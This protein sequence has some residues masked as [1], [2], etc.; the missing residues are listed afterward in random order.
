M[1]QPAPPA[2]PANKPAAPQAKGAAPPAKNVAPPAKPTPP[3]K[4][5]APPAKNVAPPAKATPPAKSAAPPAEKTAA[6]P[7]DKPAPP[8]KSAAP[9]AESVAPPAEKTAAPPA[10]K[11]AARPAGEIVT[12]LLPPL[13]LLPDEDPEQYALLREAVVSELSPSTPY[14]RIYA[15]QL[16][17]L[18][19][20]LWRYRRFRDGF[21][22]E[23]FRQ[24]CLDNMR[25]GIPDGEPRFSANQDDRQFARDCVSADTKLR[26]MALAALER[27]GY[28][29]SQ[30]VNEIYSLHGGRLERCDALIAEIENR[31]RRLREDF[32]RL[33]S[34]KARQ[35]EDAEVLEVR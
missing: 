4:G 2:P 23:K 32:D 6:P 33:K 34:A 24:W 29:P 18:E 11:P 27:A 13:D 9:P 17:M 15:D 10:D 21:I 14:Q 1:A 20:E 12:D 22:R 35:I 19:W 16:V 3:A 31:R 28:P 7:A 5:A 25:T 30:I 26:A 8:A